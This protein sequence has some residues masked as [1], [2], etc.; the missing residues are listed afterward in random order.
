MANLQEMKKYLNK[1]IVD[2][3]CVT[4]PD[5]KTFERKFKNYIK[6]VAQENNG[7]LVRFLPN[8]YEFSCF[9]KRN[10]KYV[11]ISIDDV[12][13]FPKSWYNNILIRTAQSDKDYTGGRNDYTSLDY[14]GVKIVQMTK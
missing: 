8:H 12:R 4:S 10:D 1:G 2:Y 14:L 7:E 3:G 9:V 11:Y 5:Y 13:Y 6:K